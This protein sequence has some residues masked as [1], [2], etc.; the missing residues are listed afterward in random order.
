MWPTISIVPEANT[1]NCG[2]CSSIYSNG[3]LKVCAAFLTAERQPDCRDDPIEF[4]GADTLFH[5]IRCISD[6]QV[7][8]TDHQ[9][10]FLSRPKSTFVLLHTRYFQKITG[11][12]NRRFGESNC[13]FFFCIMSVYIPWK[14]DTIFS[15][16][17]C[18]LCLW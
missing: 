9:R 11:I 16:I 10:W 4:R 3:S 6:T 18:L 7:K 8:I 17:Y 14:Y 1:L 5:T 12:F 2:Q 13:H 15:C